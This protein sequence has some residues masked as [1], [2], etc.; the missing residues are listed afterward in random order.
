MPRA[1]ALLSDFD[2]EMTNLRRAL[3]RVPAERWDF[4]PHAKAMTV[5]GL[6]GHLA[7]IPGWIGGLLERGSYDVAMN[8]QPEPP[9]TKEQMLALFDA[10]RTRARAA[11][12]AFPDARFAEPWRLLRGGE[13]VSILS[14]ERAVRRFLLEHV[15]HH[16]G[17]LTVYL[18]LLDV[19]VPALYGSSTDEPA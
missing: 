5:G 1:D 2:H 17:Q 16:R 13:V 15:I 7:R 3:E 11:L 8:T 9:A 12:E 4:R 14:R 19:P 6:A 18:R 10:S